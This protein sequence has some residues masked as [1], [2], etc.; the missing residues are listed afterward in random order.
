MNR[1]FVSL[2]TFVLSASVIQVYITRTWISSDISLLFFVAF[3]VG[4]F[5]TWA[6]IT[7]ERGYNKQVSVSQIVDLQ[8][9]TTDQHL[10]ESRR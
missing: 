8:L 10:R 4:M 6:K 3:A 5:L 2:L 1:K 9:K 7:F